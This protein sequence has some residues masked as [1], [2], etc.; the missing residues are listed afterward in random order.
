MDD[1]DGPRVAKHIYKTIFGGEK[2]TLHTE[3]IPYALDE[4]VQ[5]MRAEGVSPSRWAQFIHLGP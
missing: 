3:D 5:A 4:A 2:F 1:A